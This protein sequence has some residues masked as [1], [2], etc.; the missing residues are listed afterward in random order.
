MKKIDEEENDVAE[1]AVIPEK[2]KKTENT[3]NRPLM[4]NWHGWNL[5]YMYLK[6]P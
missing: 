1:G 5:D 4:Q 3:V 2:H 6:F